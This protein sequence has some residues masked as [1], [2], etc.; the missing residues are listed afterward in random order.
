MKA[1]ASF[2]VLVLIAFLIGISAAYISFFRVQFPET[3]TATQTKIGD[4]CSNVAG[5][6][7]TAH[8][9]G[10]GFQHNM[11]L[12]IEIDNQSYSITVANQ[13]VICRRGDYTLIENLL[14][15]RVNNTTGGQ[16]FDI[17]KRQ[18]KIENVRGTVVIS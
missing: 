11:T 3:G 10:Y 18:I 6:I 13:T 7:N 9:L 8:E 16:S 2:E 15:S 5:K 1:Q 4:I 17:P 14:T 12:P